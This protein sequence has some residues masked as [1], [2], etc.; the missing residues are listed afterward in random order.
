MG[1]GAQ[2]RP[3]ELG[4]AKGGGQGR[5]SKIEEVAASSANE[6]LTL[7]PRQIT[8]PLWSPVP[9]SAQWEQGPKAV[10]LSMAGGSPDSYGDFKAGCGQ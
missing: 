7:S 2:R 10:V 8:P 5:G 3:F 9:P 1:L 4:W 6:L